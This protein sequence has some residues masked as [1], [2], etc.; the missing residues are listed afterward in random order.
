MTITSSKKKL[1]FL[2]VSLLLSSILTFA[3]PPSVP[4]GVVR[5]RLVR[6]GYPAPHIGVSLYNQYIGSS[7]VAYTD[8]EGMY[9]LYNVPPGE[10]FLQIW[11]SNQP[12]V[13]KIVVYN[14]PYTDIPPIGVP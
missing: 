14:Q 1:G 8:R 4:A 2:G 5:G 3:V 10:Y 6:N 7:S 9:Y 12:L 11:I 13:Y